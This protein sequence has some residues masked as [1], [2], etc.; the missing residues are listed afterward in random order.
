MIHC[1]AFSKWVGNAVV[2]NLPEAEGSGLSLYRLKVARRVIKAQVE[3][4]EPEWA[5]LTSN[6]LRRVQQA[7]PKAPVVGW[8]T[9]LAQ[10]RR[11]DA[12]R[13]PAG[14]IAEEMASGTLV[15]SAPE[16]T[17]VTE[18]LVLAVR[19]SLGDAVLPGP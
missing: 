4:W 1:G 13:L 9:Y 6:S 14:V 18:P 17:D 12:D 15:T 2:L 7:P 19:K 8:I 10:P 11:V 5:T 16:V 3:S